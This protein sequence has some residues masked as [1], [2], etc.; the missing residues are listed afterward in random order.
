MLGEYLVLL[1]EKMKNNP[2]A[3]LENI[4]NKYEFDDNLRNEIKM[5]FNEFI[6]NNKNINMPVV[7][8]KIF[9]ENNKMKID[10]E[11]NKFMVNI[12]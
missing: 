4:S 1:I 7:F 6:K 5:K 3:L 2:D 9:F 11:H 12:L 8:L 10:E